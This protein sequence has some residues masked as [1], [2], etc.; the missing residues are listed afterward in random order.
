MTGTIYVLQNKVNGK[1][2]VGQTI[3]M[4]SQRIK[5]HR[6]SKTSLIARAIRKYGLD[7]FARY[8]YTGIAMDDLD[9]CEQ[10][11]ICRLRSSDRHGYNIM[12]GGQRTRKV[13]HA[14]GEKISRAN[15][16]KIAWNRGQPCSTE[17][18]KRISNSLMGNIPWNKGKTKREC[19]SL[20][21]SKRGMRMSPESRER[22][23]RAHLGKPLSE[24]NRLHISLA[25]KGK[26][27]PPGFGERQRMLNLGRVVSL[28]TRKRISESVK[29]Y[30]ADRKEASA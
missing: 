7:A 21:S 8:E 15:K 19:P 26:K 24:M 11:L 23:R 16:G 29:R 10:E 30:F 3:K 17:M 4:L 22:M 2:Y 18:R 20:T 9:Y 12:E 13:G 27:K 6:Y 25:N 28:D 14:V 1:C 5:E